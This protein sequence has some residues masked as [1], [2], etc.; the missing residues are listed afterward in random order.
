[1]ISADGTR[2][3]ELVRR[4]A[5]RGYDLIL[6]GASGYQHPLGGEFLGEILKDPPTH[7]AIVKARDEKPRYEHILVPTADDV[8][9]QLAVEFA[10]MYAEDVGAQV[11][12]LHVLPSP[13]PR[14]F[15]WLRRRQ[16][17]LDDNVLKMMADTMLWEMRPTGT[18]AELRLAAKVIEGE[19]PTEAILREALQGNYDL[20]VLGVESRTGRAGTMLSQGTEQIVNQ[21]PCTVV[22]MFPRGLRTNFIH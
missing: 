3:G 2:E 4:E 17:G 14:R 10:I 19:R 5:Q 13:E 20:V 12:L 15:R 18:K 1:V 21:V 9:S 7:V 6:L 22:V 8:Y 11:T 16:D